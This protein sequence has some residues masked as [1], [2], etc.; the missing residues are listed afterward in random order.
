MLKRICRE[1]FNKIINYSFKRQKAPCVRVIS[2]L[3]ISKTR[4]QLEITNAIE[5]SS[6]AKQLS[7]K[8]VDIIDTY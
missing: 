7:T 6:I 2:F 4:L 1:N 5:I 8:F 3:S